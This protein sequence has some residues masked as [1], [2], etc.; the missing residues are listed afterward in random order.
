M[1]WE[2]RRDFGS[3]TRPAT[4]N[5]DSMFG[6]MQCAVLR[7]FSNTAIFAAILY[8]AIYVAHS[9]SRCVFSGLETSVHQH[10]PF[11][12]IGCK[13][14]TAAYHHADTIPFSASNRHPNGYAAASL[15]SPVFEQLPPSVEPPW[16]KNPPDIKRHRQTTTEASVSYAD[17]LHEQFADEEGKD[18]CRMKDTRD[19]RKVS[20]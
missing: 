14:Y 10:S 2:D 15:H 20:E 19:H 12:I 11:T 18:N 5:T 1:V 3:L 13:H 17:F 9:L 7:F 8:R 4:L 16:C 6:A